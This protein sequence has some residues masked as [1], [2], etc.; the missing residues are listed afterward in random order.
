[1]SKYE[2]T[3]YGKCL[4]MKFGDSASATALARLEAE[5]VLALLEER[6]ALLAD[7][8]AAQE[9]NS[10]TEITARILKK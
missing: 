4:L 6:R 8:V 9:C 3:R 5:S 10:L 1:M 7:A 2:L